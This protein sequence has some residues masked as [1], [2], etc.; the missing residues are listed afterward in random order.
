[1]KKQIFNNINKFFPLIIIII[2]TLALITAY[3]LR[4][5]LK[6][7]TVYLKTLQG[8][9]TT[10]DDI[11]ITG[12]LFDSLES[13]DFEIERGNIT[14]KLVIGGNNYAMRRRENRTLYLDKSN[15][16]AETYYN[17]P[18][19]AINSFMEEK[20]NIMYSENK[21]QK[22]IYNTNK[23]QPLTT[24]RKEYSRYYTETKILFPDCYLYSPKSEFNI[25][26]TITYD[27]EDNITDI[28][29]NYSN[30]V[31]L[32]DLRNLIAI[33]GD[34][35]YIL[36]TDKRYHG[37]SGIYKINDSYS[38]IE[39][40]DYLT[41][42]ETNKDEKILNIKNGYEKLIDIDLK[43]GNTCV[44]G[45]EVVGDKIAVLVSNNTDY[46]VWLFD[47]QK[48]EF[49]SKQSVIESSEKFYEINIF[50]QENFINF[51]FLDST[52]KFNIV[53]LDDKNSIVNKISD[54]SF[55][56]VDK[57]KDIPTTTGGIYNIY[58]KNGSTYINIS[59]LGENMIL[60]F[61]G[62]D[63]KYTGQIV[64]DRFMDYSTTDSN[65][66]IYA[67]EIR[68]LSIIYFK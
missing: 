37:S 22:Y 66:R 64:T 28:Y 15:Y 59:E 20:E 40:T 42:K 23:L 63:K 34:I 48:K 33:G 62:L 5:N 41:A 56:L 68:D 32:F 43:D 17:S 16:S 8:D 11:I 39:V 53:T 18:D 38:N 36:P 25:K 46:Q 55:S 52:G 58:Y 12:S 54:S 65:S 51:Y 3:S 35:Y 4:N 45:M 57:T 24:I 44:Y 6:N 47:P 10:L 13:I 2:L 30:D 67:N 14:K 21:I 31:R 7:G 60:V 61:S 26:K 1:M 9:S 29:I 27:S 19:D 50:A 49:I